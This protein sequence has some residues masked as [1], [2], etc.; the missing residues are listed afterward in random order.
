MFKILRAAPSVVLHWNHPFVFPVVPWPTPTVFFLSAIFL[1]VSIWWAASIDPSQT[2]WLCLCSGRRLQET[3]DNTQWGKANQCNITWGDIWKRTHW[4]KPYKCVFCDWY[5]QRATISAHT[6][7]STVVINVSN[8]VRVIW[9][10][11]DFWRFFQNNFRGFINIWNW[12]KRWK[13]S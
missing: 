10:S 13:R 4:G 2:M 5:F 12:N 6:C 11:C 9:G 1:F 3:F 8:V 7:R